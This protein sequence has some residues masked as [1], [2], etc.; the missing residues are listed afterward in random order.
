MLTKMDALETAI[1]EHP[2]AQKDYDLYWLRK[3]VEAWRARFPNHK[4]RPQDDCIDLKN[5]NT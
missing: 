5:W 1:N 3:E 4:Y 2:Q